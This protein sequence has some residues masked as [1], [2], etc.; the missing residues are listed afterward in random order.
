MWT[1]QSIW[2]DVVCWYFGFRENCTIPLEV[3]FLPLGICLHIL[4]FTFPIPNMPLYIELVTTLPFTQIQW[5][6][7]H[8]YTGMHMMCC[9]MFPVVLMLLISSGLYLKQ[10]NRH[11]RTAD[12]VSIIMPGETSTRDSQDIV[13][14]TCSGLFIIWMNNIPL[15]PYFNIHFLSHMASQDGIQIYSNTYLMEGHQANKSLLL[16]TQFPACRHVW[17][18]FQSSYEVDWLFQQYIVAC[19]W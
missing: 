6:H 7:T 2:M 1:F 16:D 19:G 17:A 4:S 13:L 14:F 10:I 11:C 5:Q 9:R 18:N 8:M 3:C 15:M 12:E